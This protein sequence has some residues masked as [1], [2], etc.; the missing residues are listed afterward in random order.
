MYSK[1]L[2][3][4]KI[5][6]TF[7]DVLVVPDASAVEPNQVITRTQL[8]RNI[9]LNI[10]IVS[11]PMD[12]VTEADMAIAM[13]RLGG[14]GIIHRNMKKDLQA[15]LVKRVKREESLII[16]DLF[17]VTPDTS[18]A[19]AIKIMNERKI[20]GLPVV[21]GKKL[22]G[23][24]TSRDVRFFRDD[25]KLVKDIMTRNVVTAKENISLED[26][27]GIMA[28][29]K[30]EK[31]PLIDDQGNLVGLIT[32]KDII[33]RQQFPDAV[34]DKNGKLLVGA[35][36]GPFDI[37][38]AKLLENAGADVIVVDSAHGHNL[39]LIESVK[40]MRR[41]INVDIIAGNI[42]TSKAAEDLISADVDGLRVGIGPGSICTT[43][44]VAGIGIPQIT[45]IADVADVAENYAVP[46]IADGGIRYSGDI[47]K[48]IV[49]GASTVM[50]GSLLAG[51]DEAPGQEITI[52]G[53]RY[54]SYRGMGSLGAI[55]SGE[56]DRYGK[57]GSSKFVPEGVEGAVPYKGKVADTVYQLVGGLKAGMGYAGAKTI[58]QLRKNGKFVII[59]QAG[60]TE[61]H[62][63]DI[64]IIA[65]PPNYKVK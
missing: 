44:I 52:G 38:R 42:A 45:A 4:A 41:E 9:K 2:E 40:K 51:T 19:E 60:I 57:L 25:K 16:R 31:L 36:V 53:R 6:Y 55:S 46:V 11:S 14:I 47:V 49:A 35:A 32:A 24:L 50:L 63:H 27:L 30:I 21:E 37:E 8:S 65:E 29:K 15:E 18:I 12:T 61:S 58:D 34:R 54:K 3:N 33:K 28:E 23:I 13:A 20:A 48:A 64:M 5:A 7:D 43:R 56:H 62:P 10:P 1:K 26:A 59:T 22:V 39:N 17:I